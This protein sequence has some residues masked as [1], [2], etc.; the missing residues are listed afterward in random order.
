MG[1]SSVAT[2]VVNM[3]ASGRDAVPHEEAQR[4][5]LAHSASLFRFAHLFVRNAADAE[6]AVQDAFLRLVEHLGRGGNR[7]NLRAWLFTVT[8]NACRDRLRR[9][10]RWLPWLPEHERALTTPPDL[11]TGSSEQVFLATVALLRPRDRL[12]LGLK[13]QGLT[14]REIAAAAGI[15]EASAGR[16]LAR[17]LQRWTKA[18]ET[19][20]W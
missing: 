19:L 17:A 3:T 16:L 13:A 20:S 14:Y 10:R 8:A 2:L 15:R 1:Y 6:D 12:L 4:L 11:E 5:F 18:R 9:R 7:S